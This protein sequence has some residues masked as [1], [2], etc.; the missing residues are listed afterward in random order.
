MRRTTTTA[1]SRTRST[2]QYPATRSSSAAPST[3]PQPFAAA[4]WALGNDGIARTGDDY[5]VLA[6]RGVN[7]VTLTATSLGSA[8][9][10]GPGDLAAVNLEAFL[11]FDP[12]LAP[13]G[14]NQG[15]TISNLRILDFDLSIGSFAVG[16]SDFNNMTVTNNFI[17]IPTDLN[18]TVAPADVNQNI[19]IHFSFGTNQ[20]ISDNSFQIAGRRR[21]RHRRRELLH[22]RRDAVEPQRRNRLQRPE[23]HRQRHAHPECAVGKSAG[24]TRNLGERPAPTPAT[25]RFPTTVSSTMP[26]AIVRRSTSSAPSA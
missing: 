8:T 22:Q 13:G 20:T 16:V 18:A 24:D 2:R 7:N 19:G 15:W 5:E 14:T 17:R 3:S 21:Q 9:I 26:W 10:Q 12:S 6:P 23:H 1:A 25:S 4:A 11:V